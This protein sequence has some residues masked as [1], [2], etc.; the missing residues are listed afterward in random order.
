MIPGLDCLRIPQ[1]AP[2]RLSQIPRAL[3]NFN[4]EDRG[5]T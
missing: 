3:L 4:N 2:K 5:L 1:H